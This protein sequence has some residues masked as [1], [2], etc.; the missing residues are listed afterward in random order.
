MPVSGVGLIRRSPSGIGDNTYTINSILAHSGSKT[1]TNSQPF[2]I[3]PGA[4]TERGEA[5]GVRG[6][7]AHLFEDLFTTLTKTLLVVYWLQNHD[8]VGTLSGFVLAGVPFLR[9]GAF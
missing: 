7:L 5:G 4:K 1:A 2:Y 9:G 6:I 3:L 8:K